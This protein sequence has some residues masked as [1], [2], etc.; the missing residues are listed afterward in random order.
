MRRPSARI[1]QQGLSTIKLGTS[2]FALDDPYYL[3]LSMSW[4]AFLVSV[5]ALY[6]AANLIFATLYWASPGAVFNA[7]PGSFGDAFFFSVETLATVG[8]GEMHPQS[9]YGHGVAT[10]EIFVGVFLTALVT[11]A[12]FARFA[13]PKPRL[14]FS[15]VA[16]IGPY[17]GMTAL[18]VRVASRRLHAI[19]EVRGRISYLRTFH[20]PDGG[21]FRRF[22]DLKLV[23]SEN[24]VLSLSWTLIHPIDEDSPLHDMDEARLRNE[25]P[26]LLVSINGFDEAI[27]SQVNDRH[28][29]R[30]DEIRMGHIFVH[31]LEDMPDGAV[32]V[33]LTRIHETVAVPE[34][35]AVGFSDS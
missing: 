8:Y 16:V 2:R 27:S 14:I 5:L 3:V 7:R 11:G 30:P 28:S 26:R 25:A 18:M 6:I 9:L 15:D 34:G 24:P 17:D 13:R 31:I 29:Y 1:D 21:T 20:L 19:N 23:R 10:A 33:D 12:F 22:Y 35:Q 4:Q 32:Q